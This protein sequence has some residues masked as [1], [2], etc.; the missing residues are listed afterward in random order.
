MN[1]YNFA[2][3]FILS[4]SYGSARKALIQNLHMHPYKVTTYYTPTNSGPLVT[5]SSVLSLI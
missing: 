2:T 4:L 5:Q 1:L 3:N